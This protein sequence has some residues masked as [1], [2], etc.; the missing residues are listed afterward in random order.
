MLLSVQ[1][2]ELQ[3]DRNLQG[4]TVPF[5]QQMR[6]EAGAGPGKGTVVM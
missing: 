5:T 6:S 4:E 3:E 1:G 2:Q